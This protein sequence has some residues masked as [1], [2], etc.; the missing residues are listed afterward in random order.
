MSKDKT[1]SLLL[2]SLVQITNCS[3]YLSAVYPQLFK[4]FDCCSVLPLTMH[5]LNLFPVFTLG[6]VD[7]HDPCD[8]CF[9]VSAVGGG[10]CF[11]DKKNP[12]SGISCVSLLTLRVSAKHDKRNMQ[13]MVYVCIS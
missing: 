3:V 4:L 1:H 12:R 2:C 7:S 13:I 6:R 5:H 11:E 8:I 10:D 9:V